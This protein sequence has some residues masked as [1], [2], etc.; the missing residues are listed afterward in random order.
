MTLP[1]IMFLSEERVNNYA[2]I[3][4]IV[5]FA[6]CFMIIPFGG[7]NAFSFTEGQYYML[8]ITTVLENIA[9]NAFTV[10]ILIQGICAR[11]RTPQ[12]E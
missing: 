9:I 5:L 6:F 4:Y 12:A 3:I 8:N 1:L 2:D 11:N 10:M 7:H